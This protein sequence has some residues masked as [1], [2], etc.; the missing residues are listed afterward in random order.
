M[1]RLRVKPAVSATR[2]N[3]ALFQVQTSDELVVDLSSNGRTCYKN[4]G[5][6]LR[7]GMELSLD[8]AWRHGF[9][10]RRALTGLNA[11]YDEPFNSFA[12]VP[13]LPVSVQAGNKIPGV[14]AS[15]KCARTAAQWRMP[16]QITLIPAVSPCA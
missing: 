7:R 1:S 11:I 5:H 4:A 15:R 10:G 2:V 3:L 12:G 6:T 9:S 16:W 8:S 14:A 13:S